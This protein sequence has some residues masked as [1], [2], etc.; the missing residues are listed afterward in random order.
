MDGYLPDPN[1]GPFPHVPALGVMQ[2]IS[3]FLIDH[4]VLD[5]YVLEKFFSRTWSAIHVRRVSQE[6]SFL[7]YMKFLRYGDTR[8]GF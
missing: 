5:H 6:G 2:F 3:W 1:L 4:D 8:N 7:L